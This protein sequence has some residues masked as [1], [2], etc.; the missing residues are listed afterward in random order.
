MTHKS[1][2]F[3]TRFI[4][5]LAA[6]QVLD[7]F[8]SNYDFSFPRMLLE[9]FADSTATDCWLSSAFVFDET[10][11]GFEFWI[12]VSSEWKEIVKHLYFS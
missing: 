10:P 3:F 7:L 9:R 11:E 12:R 4:P 6:H 5:F 2:I 8:L 1:K